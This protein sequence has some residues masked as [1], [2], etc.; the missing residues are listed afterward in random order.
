MMEE[1]MESYRDA[2]DKSRDELE[3]TINESGEFKR[4]LMESREQLSRMFESKCEMAE[5]MGN[6]MH[7]MK[8]VLN[9]LLTIDKT[10]NITRILLEASYG[11]GK[12]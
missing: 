3:T 5:N 12:S 8:R 4:A 2:I 10:K 7:R 9:A 11:E 1:K 6:E